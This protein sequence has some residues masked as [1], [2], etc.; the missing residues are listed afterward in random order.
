MELDIH[1]FDLALR[2]PFT[3][4]RHTY[5][6][7]R[8][9]IV[10]LGNGRYK[11]YGEATSNPYYQVTEE[12]L[13]SSF[14]E[15]RIFLRDY[16][17]S[18]PE[19]LWSDIHPV[20]SGNT[21]AQSAIDCAAHDLFFKMKG[22]SFMSQWGISY[23]KY[24]FTSYTLG[25]GTIDEL[26]IKMKDLPWPVYKLKVKGIDDS[27]IVKELRKVSGALFRVDANCSW[28]LDES[29]KIADDLKQWKV[30][31]IEQ[32][33][34]ADL[35][36]E[37][38]VLRENSSLAIIA[39]ESCQ[40]IEDIMKCRGSFDGI[41]IKLSKCGGLT[42]AFQMMKM[43]REAGLSIMI[44]CMTETSIGISAAV[45]LLPFVDYADLDGPLLLAEDVASGL[46]YSKGSLIPG[47]GN[48]LGI[49]FKGRKFST[50]L[51]G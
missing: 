1:T 9:V 2:Y 49:E 36:E 13:L 38:R 34:D 4:S 5:N 43:A 37:S 32:P 46:T 26:K 40:K 8:S 22:E 50:S 42:P 12:N 39:D 48:G 16:R 25:I 41:N 51:P 24:P 29:T 33:F 47:K 15:A 14:E 45:Q 28:N 30:E 17:F 19:K 3:I 21:F 18:N 6:S 35:V 31:F 10:E 20:L 44:G 11:G 7:I 23:Q 27:E